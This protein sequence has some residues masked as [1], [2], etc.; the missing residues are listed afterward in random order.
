MKNKLKD[1]YQKSGLFKFLFWCVELPFYVKKFFISD[2]F[3]ISYTFRS[4]FGKKGNFKEPKTLNEVISYRKIYDRRPIYTLCSDKSEVRNYVREN[5]GEKYL[6]PMIEEFNSVK[7]ISFD[8]L[9]QGYVV[10][11][12]HGSGQN[13]VVRDKK[14]INE[15]EITNQ[16]SYWLRKNHYYNSREW[17]YK[18]IK[19]KIIVEK[20]L[21]DQSG[22][23]PNDL[24]FHCING[25]VEFIQIDVD[26][27]GEHSR[28]FYSK[29]W[30][31]LPFMWTPV[32]NGKPKYS[33]AKPQVE[34]ERLDEMIALAEKLASIFYYVR[35][36]LYFLDDQIYFGELTFSHGNGREHFIPSSWDKSFGDKIDLSYK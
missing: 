25:V 11:V 35:V 12:N 8:E 22:K 13:I 3:Y 2:V 28:N 30:Q 4:S 36:D 24:K 31:V 14:K 9:P 21:L 6:I 19:S 26:R 10:K 23:V 17:Q 18:N 33:R 34:P 5:V 27:F 20:L 29:E 16:L 7:E 15:H 1:F 32:V